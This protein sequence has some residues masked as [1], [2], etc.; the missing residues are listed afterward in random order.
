M[1]MHTALASVK[2]SDLQPSLTSLLVLIDIVVLSIRSGTT[3]WSSVLL[4]TRKNIRALELSVT[5]KIAGA[6]MH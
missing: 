6:V 2:E 4:R 3:L 5:S 1:C